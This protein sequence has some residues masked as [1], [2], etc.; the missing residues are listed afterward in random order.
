MQVRTYIWL[1]S[2]P[3]SSKQKWQPL[4]H[5]VP[6]VFKQLDGGESRQIR[7]CNSQKS[8]CEIDNH[9]NESESDNNKSG[10]ESER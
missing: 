3:Q 1:Q 8:E 7:P 9:K 10:S 2:G 5:R 6:S 4:S